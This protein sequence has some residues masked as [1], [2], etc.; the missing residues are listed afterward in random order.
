MSIAAIISEKVQE[1]KNQYPEAS[2]DSAP[3]IADG[4]NFMLYSLNVIFQD[5]DF[6]KLEEGIVDSSFR[7]TSHD[8]GIDAV[9]ITCNGSF[10]NSVE[11]LDEFNNDSKLEFHILQFKKGQGSDQAS[12]L[13]LKEGIKKC[14]IEFSCESDLNEYLY[15]K[16]QTL[17]EIRNRAYGIFEPENIKLSI[18][19]VFSGLKENVLSDVLLTEQIE[20]TKKLLRTHCYSVCSYE[21]IGGQEL[22]NLE[23]KGKEIVDVISY[24]NTFKY[25]TATNDSTKLAGHICIVK[26]S[27]IAEL[28]KKYQTSLF[29]SNIRDFYRK[30][31]LNSTILKTSSDTREAKYFWSY[32]NGL[33]ITCRKVD[34]LPGN[35]YRL[36]GIQIVNGCQTSNA[37]YQAF[38]NKQVV[39]ALISKGISNLTKSE[40][41]AYEG[42][43]NLQLQN[44]TTILARIIET[45][46]AD[47]TY[48]ITE[49]TNSQTPIKSFS[50]KAND[51][52][53]KNIHEYLLQKNIYYERR[54]NFYKNQG[55][56]NPVSIQTL[57]QLYV[58]HVLFRPSQVK[59]RPASMFQE[60]YDE[61]FPSPARKS[62][63]YCIYLVSIRVDLALKHYIAKVKR[64]HE[65]TD[66]YLL[67]LFANGRLHLGC[68]FLYSILE[69]RYNLKGIIK[70]AHIVLDIL[71]KENDEEFATHFY[72]AAANLKRI[73]QNYIGQKKESIVPAL[74]KTELDIRIQK[75]IKASE[76]G[77]TT[78]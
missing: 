10:I 23:K 15:T 74:R 72:I 31:D 41:K 51:D 34:E 39:E 16:F 6:E 4:I 77:S 19:Y 44:E 17:T 45:N 29:E 14:F 5:F 33:T 52:I 62:I 54:I 11:E 37:L 27:E 64:T 57:F 53:Q 63:D 32:N 60:F 2:K 66:P 61:V 26:G 38:R 3:D 73:L 13:K 59:T 8:Y 18:Y 68:L 36:H 1:V 25:I 22:I 42:A 7:D 76:T 56:R 43:I 58:A 71:D 78:D 35:K 28:V 55:R 30:N 67:Q 40:S 24:E 12:F 20:D 49:T 48:R 65:E 47:L 21:I 75:F 69:H 50:L 70:N 46:D 9:Y